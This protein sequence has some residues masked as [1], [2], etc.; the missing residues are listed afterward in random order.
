MEQM[1]KEYEAEHRR[2]GER[3]AELR[4]LLRTGNLKTKEQEC[5][6][7]RMHLITTERTELVHAVREMRQC[8]E[9]VT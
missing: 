6:K 5:V 9:G 7:L 3:L 4:N 2:L 1:I 8:L